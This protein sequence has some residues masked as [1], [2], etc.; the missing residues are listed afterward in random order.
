MRT[1]KGLSGTISLVTARLRH[2]YMKSS[3]GNEPIRDIWHAARVYR[4]DVMFEAPEA[5]AALMLCA[6]FATLAGL[7]AVHHR[8]R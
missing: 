5:R 7:A 1:P 6:G 2:A 3:D 4:M 8:K